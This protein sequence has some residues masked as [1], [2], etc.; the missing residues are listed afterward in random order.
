L[1]ADYSR[2]VSDSNAVAGLSARI[3]KFTS[4]AIC[5]KLHNLVA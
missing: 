3:C 1:A 4:P 5:K 2:Q